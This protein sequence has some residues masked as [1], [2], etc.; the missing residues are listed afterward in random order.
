MAKILLVDDSALMRERCA[1]LLINEG[2]EIF[3]AENGEEGLAMY[4]SIKPD[5]TFMDITMPV[6]D[7]IKAVEEIIKTDP[8]AVIIMLSAVGQTDKVRSAIKNGAKYFLVKPYE[9]K[10]ILDVLD[11]FLPK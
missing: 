2:H 5:A 1:K 8:N 10:K 11:K 4:T 3:Q 6:M 9:P 7:G